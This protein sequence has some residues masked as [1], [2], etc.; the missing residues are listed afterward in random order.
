MGSLAQLFTHFAQEFTTVA[1]PVILGVV[2]VLKTPKAPV[3]V[4]Y[5]CKVKKLWL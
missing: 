3:E 1:L 2:K 5:P 4:L